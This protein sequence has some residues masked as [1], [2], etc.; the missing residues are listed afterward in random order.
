MSTTAA[1]RSPTERRDLEGRDGRVGLFGHV[2][3]FGAGG[4]VWVDEGGPVAVG[5]EDFFGNFRE[6]GGEADAA[7][8]VGVEFGDGALFFGVL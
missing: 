2:P 5:V 7:G 4:V 6:F 1:P 3:V 8:D